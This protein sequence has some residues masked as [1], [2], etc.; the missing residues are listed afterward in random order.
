MSAARNAHRGGVEWSVRSVQCAV[1][2]NSLVYSKKTRLLISARNGR[3]QLDLSGA[4]RC[5]SG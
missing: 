3:L 2:P 1:L 5:V 4:E